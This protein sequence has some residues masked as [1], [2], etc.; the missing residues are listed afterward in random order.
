MGRKLDVPKQREAAVHEKVHTTSGNGVDAERRDCDAGLAGCS[1][2]I[3]AHREHR[4]D[5]GD[6]HH[7][8]GGGCAHFRVV[9]SARRRFSVRGLIRRCWEREMSGQPAV[10]STESNVEYVGKARDVG[11]T[12]D[13]RDVDGV[14]RRRDEGEWKVR[15]RTFT[16]A[17]EGQPDLAGCNAGPG[18]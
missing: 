18:I 8:D 6:D 14:G 12:R 7:E 13:R 1:A 17:A 5:D 4:T 11:W 2:T 15:S 9:V 16:E 10:Q 3:A